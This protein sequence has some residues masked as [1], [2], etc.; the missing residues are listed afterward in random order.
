[1]THSMQV[2]YVLPGIEIN[3]FLNKQNLAS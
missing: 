2:T 3:F 1:M